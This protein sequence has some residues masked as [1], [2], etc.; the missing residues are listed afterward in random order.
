MREAGSDAIQE[1]AFTFSN[2]ISYIDAAIDRGLDVNSFA[3]RISFFI[4]TG[5]KLKFL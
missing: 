2:A 4:N 5:F 3:K 1:L